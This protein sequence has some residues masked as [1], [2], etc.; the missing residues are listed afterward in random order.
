MRKQTGKVT[1]SSWARVVKCVRRDTRAYGEEVFL[2]AVCLNML[3]P[4][5]DVNA[6]EL[7]FLSFDCSRLR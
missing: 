2:F 4:P 7:A 3:A 5:K 1:S 6:Y